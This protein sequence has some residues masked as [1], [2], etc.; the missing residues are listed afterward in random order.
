MSAAEAGK[1]YL[2]AVCPS[3]ILADKAA[4]TVQTKPLDLLAAKSAAAALRDS[5]RKTIETLSDQKVMWPEAV[6]PDVATL[7]EAMYADLSGAEN[8]ANQTTDANLIAAWNT[9]VNSPPPAATAQKIRLKLGIPA[10]T[11]SSC[12]P[13]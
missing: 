2:A 13:S 9:W 1:A 4:T 5:Y 6:K 8:V 3:N 10:D 12:T 7:A 11:A